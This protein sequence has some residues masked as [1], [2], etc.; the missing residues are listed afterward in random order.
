MENNIIIDMEE[1][2]KGERKSTEFFSDYNF[3]NNIL[4]KNFTYYDTSYLRSEK[5]T[6]YTITL[7]IE[8]RAKAKNLVLHREPSFT[9]LK[10]FKEVINPDNE[11]KYPDI[12]K[13]YENRKTL[14][15]AVT[16]ILC[17]ILYEE[18]NKCLEIS[19]LER[20]LI[21]PIPLNVQDTLMH[22]IG[23]GNTEQYFIT[24]FQLSEPIQN[25]SPF[26]S[27]ANSLAMNIPNK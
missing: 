23:F 11:C 17:R 14:S 20:D 18:I 24:G 19:L 2:R 3:P 21:H 25:N 7:V 4:I 26:F 27:A 12:Y 16:G 22:D 6:R 15:G 5:F 13:E 8:K 1:Y 10:N 9:T